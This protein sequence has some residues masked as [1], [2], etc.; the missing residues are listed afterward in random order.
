MQIEEQLFGKT[1]AQVPVHLY[2]LRNAHGME[3]QITNYGGIV[4]S[5]KAPDRQGNWEDVV[6]GFETL[7]DY[8]HK[9]TPYFGAVIGRYANR[10]AQGCFSID[11][12]TFQLTK[13]EGENHLH[14]GHKG[15]HAVVWEAKKQE[16][17]Q[18]AGLK[19]HT[20]SRDGEEGY[21]GNLSVSVTYRLTPDN[22]LQLDYEATTDQATVLNLTHHSYFNLSGPRLHS[23]LENELRIH[24]DFFT[25][26]GEGLIPT[27]EVRAVKGTVLDFRQAM[28]MQTHIGQGESSL[29]FKGS[30]DVNFVLN[31]PN[32]HLRHAATVHEPES[33]RVLEVLTTEPALQLYTACNLDGTLVG[34]GGVAY[35]QHAGLCLEAQHFPN[36]PNQPNFPA[37]L[38]LPGKTYRQTTLY[39]FSTRAL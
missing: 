3:A 13:N 39:R 35:E 11:H 30:Y 15:F 12:E 27:G 18:G 1:E 37:T 14:G 2:T 33:G 32:G 26:V 28:R 29:L 16:T 22:A 20:L 4:V 34:K 31:P 9:N 6:L 21:P 36:S 38:L 7:E 19:L 23:V 10:I 24:A 8:I 25:P 17:A 5:L